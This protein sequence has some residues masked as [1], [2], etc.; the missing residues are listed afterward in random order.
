MNFMKTKNIITT[1]ALA[2]SLAASFFFGKHQE[3]KVHEKDRITLTVI[4]ADMPQFS[5]K[6]ENPEVSLHANFGGKQMRLHDLASL[7]QTY[8]PHQPKV[9]ELERNRNLYKRI[10]LHT[11][12]SFTLDSEGREIPNQKSLDFEISS[13][14]LSDG[15]EAGEYMAYVF[16]I[17]PK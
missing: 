6:V 15:G 14:Y 13:D 4:Y 17:T 8:D 9:P 1:A 11:S 12:D 10:L 16:N 5:G 7:A 3:R 2:A